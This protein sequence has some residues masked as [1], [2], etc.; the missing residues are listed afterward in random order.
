MSRYIWFQAYFSWQYLFFYLLPQV[1][2]H[3]DMILCKR[4]GMFGSTDSLSNSSA[5][6]NQAAEQAK[7]I[8]A[9]KPDQQR[10]ASTLANRSILM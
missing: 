1:N 5:E 10:W 2:G 9:M 8:N 7:V 6:A 4:S 3:P